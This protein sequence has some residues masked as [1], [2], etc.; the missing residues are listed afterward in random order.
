VAFLDP[1]QALV[2]GDAEVV[3][4]ALDGA[5][6]PLEAGPGRVRVDLATLQVLVEAGHPAAA[7]ALQA[8]LQREPVAR[9]AVTWAAALEP[10]GASRQAELARALA[11]ALAAWAAWA[12]PRLAGGLAPAGPQAWPEGWPGV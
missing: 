10:S 9:W 2:L 3:L 6:R 12:G 1:G 5:T 8:A 7:T 11:D 4:E